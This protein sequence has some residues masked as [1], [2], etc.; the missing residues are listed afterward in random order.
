MSAHANPDFAQARIA[1][2][3][4]RGVVSVTG[5][6]AESFLDNLITNDM[7]ALKAPGDALHAGLLSP[8]GKILFEFF[9]VKTA[10]GFLLETMLTETAALAKR[11]SLY[12][13]RAKVEIKDAAGE[14][15]VAVSQGGVR[16]RPGGAITFVDPRDPRLGDRILIP[17]P[18]VGETLAQTGAAR[19]TADA[20]HA[21]RIAI[22]VPDAA[23]DYK[24]GDAFPHEAGFDEFKGVSFTKGCFVGQ[25]VVARMQNK[26]VVR[27]RIVRMTAPAALAHGADVK[28]GEAVIGTIGSTAGPTALGLVRLDRIVEAQDK[29]QPVTVN[30]AE[31]TVDPDAIARYRASVAE[32]AGPGL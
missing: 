21:S 1:L 27:K 25:E 15:V 16:A 23:T 32:K 4:D 5:P 19:M 18:A 11:L 3:A 17:A 31:V 29:G 12:K 28:A 22:G 26:T 9:V 2:L 8:Q 20:Y 24:L 10:A 13:L 7:S 6:E 30:G 14:V